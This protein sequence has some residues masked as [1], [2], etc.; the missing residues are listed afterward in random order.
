M[1]E[2]QKGEEEEPGEWIGFAHIY[3]GRCSTE[4]IPD[5]EINKHVYTQ[6]VGLDSK[7]GI[8]LTEQLYYCLNHSLRLDLIKVSMECKL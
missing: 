8:T 7:L 4:S 5:D 3:L 2:F 1:E 6:L